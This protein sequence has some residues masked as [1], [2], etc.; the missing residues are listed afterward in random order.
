M[1]RSSNILISRLNQISSMNDLWWY[2]L[3]LD[4]PFD[5]GQRERMKGF[6]DG[7]EQI[8]LCSMKMWTL[9]GNQITIPNEQVANMDLNYQNMRRKTR[10]TRV[11]SE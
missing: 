3:A 10:S 2:R 6:E 7:M 1:V 5:A 11:S 4:K 8:G 9:A